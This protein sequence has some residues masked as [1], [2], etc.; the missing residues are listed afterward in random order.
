MAMDEQVAGLWP[1]ACLV[2]AQPQHV[3]HHLMQPY[4]NAVWVQHGI[5]PA[6]S[7]KSRAA[8]DYTPI[9]VEPNEPTP[10]V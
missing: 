4:E 6:R 8:V 1:G 5:D 9:S 3:V 7:H 10:G 2:V